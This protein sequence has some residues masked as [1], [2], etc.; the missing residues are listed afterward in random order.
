VL[1]KRDSGYWGIFVDKK[2]NLCFESNI[3]SF[4]P[5]PGG[6]GLFSSK[7]VTLLGGTLYAANGKSLIFFGEKDSI[8]ALPVIGFKVEIRN[9]GDA[10]VNYGF[11]TEH[12]YKR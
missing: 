7:I 6:E 4:D 1:D 12:F 2:K 8:T 10:S 3:I 11:A 9:R 5:S